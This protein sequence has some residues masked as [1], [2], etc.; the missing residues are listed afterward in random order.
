MRYYP[1]FKTYP[2]NLNNVFLRAL[3]RVELSDRSEKFDSKSEPDSYLMPLYTRNY[4]INLGISATE[5]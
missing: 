4:V 5:V 3:V 2:E 1:C